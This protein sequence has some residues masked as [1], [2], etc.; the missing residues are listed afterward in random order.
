MTNG[1]RRFPPLKHTYSNAAGTTTAEISENL[2]RRKEIESNCSRIVCD[3]SSSYHCSSKMENGIVS[4]IYSMMEN[5]FVFLNSLLGNIANFQGV[6]SNFHLDKP[7]ND[8][9]DEDNLNSNRDDAKNKRLKSQKNNR[10]ALPPNTSAYNGGEHDVSGGNRVSVGE[11][12]I[13]VHETRHSIIV[14]REKNDYLLI[15]GSVS[16]QSRELSRNGFKRPYH[17]RRNILIR[18]R[19]K[20]SGNSRHEYLRPFT[21][22]KR[23][24]GNKI[25]ASQTGSQ[26]QHRPKARQRFLALPGIPEDVETLSN[27]KQANAFVTMNNASENVITQQNS[28]R[29]NCDAVTDCSALS[30]DRCS[31]EKH[32]VINDSLNGMV[33]NEEI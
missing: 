7:F 3:R 26:M 18:S 5:R 22:F 13:N 30:I 23:L 28:K 1:L 27:G 6:L 15:G 19:L 24:K 8:S 14:D 9:H 2:L 10:I 16:G 17:T 31:T 12:C 21:I 32:Q 4:V 33:V 25:V 11:Q 20:S 29:N